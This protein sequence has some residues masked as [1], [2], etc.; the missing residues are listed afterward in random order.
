M[1]G[2]LASRAAQECAYPC[3]PA[4]CKDPIESDTF[5][6]MHNFP[7]RHSMTLCAHQ[8][9]SKHTYCLASMLSEVFLRAWG[10]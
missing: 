6:C 3:V 10:A 5:G 2:C 7:F 4:C 1:P 8:K 9:L